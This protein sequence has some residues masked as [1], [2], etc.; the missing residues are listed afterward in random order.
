VQIKVERLHP[1]ATADIGVRQRQG[2]G[3]DATQVDE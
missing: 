2:A 3:G 1:E